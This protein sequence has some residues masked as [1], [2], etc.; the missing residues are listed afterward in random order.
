LSEWWDDERE[1]EE[2]VAVPYK[3]L[4]EE[5]LRGVVESFVLREGTDYGERDVSHEQKVAQVIRQLERGEARIMFDPVSQ[6]VAIVVAK[7]GD[8]P[9]HRQR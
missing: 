5:A 1:Q 7:P 9:T 3:E 2:P 4:S 6:S 8:E